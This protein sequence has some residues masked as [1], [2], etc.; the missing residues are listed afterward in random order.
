LDRTLC[1]QAEVAVPREPADYASSIEAFVGRS[2]D[3]VIG[4]SFLLTEELMVAAKAH[5]KITFLLVDPLTRPD[6]PSSNLV[7]LTFREDQAGYLAGALEGLMTR[8]GVVGGVYGLEAGA[9][10]RYRAGFE[11]GVR[12]TNAAAR[13]LGR[14]QQPGDGVPYNNPAWGKQVAQGWFDQG[15]DIVFGA[16]GLTGHGELEAALTAQRMCIGI[17]TDEFLS[18][19]EAEACLLTSAVKNVALAVRMAI[20]AAVQGRL[21]AGS[22][23]TFDSS[24]GGVGLAPFHNFDAQVP[25][26]VRARL[27]QTMAGLAAGSLSTGVSP[28]KVVGAVLQCPRKES[29]QRLNLA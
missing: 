23:L 21:P 22:T 4:S 1:L 24:N 15:A 7:S 25:A 6:A 18:D 12:Y 3:L 14:Y 27:A 11:Q 20:T 5:P 9:I 26:A 13:I 19:P 28:V 16:G 10:T 29:R 17:D 8:S 2:F